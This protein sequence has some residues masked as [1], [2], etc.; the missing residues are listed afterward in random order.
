MPKSESPKVKGSL[1]NFPISEIDS[2][3]N[4]LFRPAG[5]NKVIIMEM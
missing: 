2:N 4:S 1:C 5:S 3:C